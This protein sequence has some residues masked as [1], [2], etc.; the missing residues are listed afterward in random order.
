VVGGA[1]IREVD[2]SLCKLISNF[3]TQPRT[4]IESTARTA[5]SSELGKYGYRLSQDPEIHRLA[6]DG[7]L[8]RRLQE[9]WALY[10]DH[11]VFLGP[12]AARFDNLD[13]FIARLARS[14][15]LPELVFIRGLGVLEGARFSDAERA[16]IKC[17]CDV[18]LRQADDE[19]LNALSDEDIAQLLNWD[20]EKYRMSISSWSP[21]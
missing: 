1:G 11:V 2:D 19:Q 6:I 21:K 10:P 8:F 18:L 15:D 5:H 16:Q 20:A 13:D 12:R 7:R 4:G 9:D 3:K 17:Y 14:H